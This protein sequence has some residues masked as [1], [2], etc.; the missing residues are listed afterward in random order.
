MQLT[1]AY[2]YNLPRLSPFV[3]DF[4]F[5]IWFLL[6]AA[7]AF[8]PLLTA[9]EVDEL[10]VPTALFDQ[11]F[12]LPTAF[13]IVTFFCGSSVPHTKLDIMVSSGE[14]RMARL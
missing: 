7:R 11:A 6:I 10:I 9:T 3:A 14:C 12:S 8:V 13:S 4:P 2:Q 5:Q 1:L